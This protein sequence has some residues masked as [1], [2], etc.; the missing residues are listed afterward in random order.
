MFTKRR[1]L[2]ARQVDFEVEFSDF[3]DVSGLW[4]QNEKVAGTGMALTVASV[5]GGR[6]MGGFGWVDGAV[7]AARVMGTQN[8]RRLIVPGLIAAGMSLF[9]SSLSAPLFSTSP[10]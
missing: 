5:L 6:M 3:F 10:R 7:G 9:M 1:D 2:L 8:M 4:E